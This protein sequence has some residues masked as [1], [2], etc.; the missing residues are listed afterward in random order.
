M[1]EERFYVALDPKGEPF[2]IKFLKNQKIGFFV[3]P[4]GGF[5]DSE[6]EIFKQKRVSIYFL[7]A[8]I[9]RA[10]TAALAISSVALLSH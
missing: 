7:G 8:Q 6:L 5:D 9:L 3:G 2:D 4:E 1:E 10:E